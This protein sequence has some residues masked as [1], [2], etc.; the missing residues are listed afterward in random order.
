V[1]ETDAHSTARA[2]ATHSLLAID[3][4][5]T[6]VRALVVRGENRQESSFSGLKTDRELFAQLAEVIAAVLANSEGPVTLAIG[7][8]GLT[9]ANS[10]PEALLALVPSTVQRVFLA[11]DSITGFLGSMGVEHGTVTAVGTGVVTLAVGE[12]EWA[13][14]DGWGNL[15]GDS[16]SAYWIGR[17]GLE[18]AMRAYDGRIP[19]TQLSALL[20]D[21]FTNPEEAY[22]ELQTS[23]D[24]VSKIAALAKD[25]IALADSDSAARD[26][27]E[28][29]GRELAHSAVTAARR[30]GL[31]DAPAPRFSW[32]G[33]VMKA[34]V[35]RHAFVQAITDAVPGADICEP[36]GEPIDGVALLPAVS[37]TSPIASVIHRAH[38]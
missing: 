33:N 22:I 26:I 27:V 34:S 14:V 30:T 36:F 29:A 8:T 35:L 32:A 37:A 19:P 13:R 2:D 25:I 3:A 21:N 7:M 4:G 24:R 5:Q 18:A 17:A 11:H 15:I 16:G 12:T 9:V 28:S 31:L 23:D 20:N 6:G 10:R 38:R 1:H